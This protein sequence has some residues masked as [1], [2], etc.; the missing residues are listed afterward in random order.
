MSS[1]NTAPA[2]TQGKG[3]QGAA[4]PARDGHSVTKRY[5]P[6]S[7][8]LSQS[9]LSNF[10]ICFVFVC[11]SGIH[12]LQQELRTL[13]V[14]G[15]NFCVVF[16][17]CFSATRFVFWSIISVVSPVHCSIHVMA[18]SR[19]CNTKVWPYKPFVTNCSRVVIS[20]TCSF[21]IGCYNEASALY[22]LQM[23]GHGQDYG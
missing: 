21:K 6:L 9:H 1:Q 23:M 13:M 15:D 3:V 17:S 18:W 22:L 16:F 14:G 8:S 2:S 19:T 12:R 4:G 10:K 5:V 11:V 20:L 7:L